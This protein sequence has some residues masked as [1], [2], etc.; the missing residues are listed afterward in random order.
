L[1]RPGQGSEINLK[2]IPIPAR[3]R[4]AVPVGGP[5]DRG[6][7]ES[8]PDFNLVRNVVLPDA[9]KQPDRYLVIVMVAIIEER[10]GEI[11]QAVLVDHKKVANKMFSGMGPLA[12]SSAKI[13]LGFLLGMYREGFAKMLHAVRHSATS[14]H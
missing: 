6:E 7:Q 5:H 11:L 3:E 13:D 2:A 8:D 10:L 12:T 1:H 14:S 9:K 4:P